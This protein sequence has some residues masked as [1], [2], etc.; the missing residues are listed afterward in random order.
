MTRISRIALRL[1]AFN[2]LVLFVPVAGVL[3][4]D[5]YE[6][7]LREAQESALVQQARVLAA[8]LG[9]TP[10]PDKAR[11]SAAFARLERRSEARFR[12]FGPSGT[13]IADSAQQLDASPADQ[14]VPYG[15]DSGRMRT[16]AL[17]RFGAW[18]VQT[19]RRMVAP[20]R[21]LGRQDDLGG[22][23]ETAGL[24][25]EVRA[26]LSGRYGAATRPTSGQRSLTLFSAVPI[27]HDGA[28][29]GA[30]VTSQS[31]FR[32]L[33]ALYTVR[34]R[35]FEIVIAS[36]LAASV[37]TGVAAMTIV[38]PL[39]RLRKQANTVAERRGPLPE[40]FEG[41]GRRDEI[42]ALARALGELTRRTNDH[43]K[44]VQSFG[45]DVAHELKNPLAS[46]RTA[47][48]MMAESE[49]PEERRKF[50]ELMTRDTARLERLVSGLREV[51]RLEGQIES[52]VTQSI[53]LAPLVEQVAAT[54]NQRAARG[55]RVEVTAPPGL[56]YVSASPER[57]VQVLENLVDNAVSFAPDGD[58]VDVTLKCDGRW[59]ECAVR[60]R[61]P[62]M[63]PAHLE[64]VFDR[65]FTYRPDDRQREHTGLGLAIAKQIVESYGGTLVACNRPGGG[66]E[67]TFRLP[68]CSAAAT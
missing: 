41:A 34:L 58:T 51:A 31:T 45:A 56:P 65:F 21:H 59:I 22:Q 60:D 46:I 52:D 5:V 61:G 32:T 25:P 38:R 35:L 14:A 30:V 50:F 9:E 48:E 18:L 67:F 1:F 42:G 23:A 55:V 13:L 43:V 26:A 44:L 17:Y 20:L 33:A 8:V 68:V 63:P 39:A 11:V 66:A 24:S 64:R 4:L 53:A 7:R 47:A 27:R 37:L 6:A 10:V 28:V 62:G 54:A 3:Y 57:I 15:I 2:L 12:V 29:V 16:R 49:S 36:L 40:V 19:T